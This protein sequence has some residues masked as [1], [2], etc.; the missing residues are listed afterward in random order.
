MKI[1]FKRSIGVIFV[2][3]GLLILFRSLNLFDGVV[4]NVVWVVVMGGASLYFFTQFAKSRLQSLWLM[5]GIVFLSIAASNI[6]ALFDI[7][8]WV[9]DAILFAGIGLGFT[10]FYVIDKLNWWS[11]LPAGLVFSLGLIRVL[12]QTSPDTETNGILFLGLGIT[13]LIL[14]ALPTKYSRLSWTL[15]PG[16]ALLG[17]GFLN[18]FSGSSDIT[19]YVGPGLLVL[20]GIIVLIFALRK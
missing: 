11:I 9:P 15:I 10:S 16:V 19:G 6:V 7:N 2:F 18:N 3:I 5:L 13:F 12:E 14:F 8:N 1:N 4:G 17:I 20:S